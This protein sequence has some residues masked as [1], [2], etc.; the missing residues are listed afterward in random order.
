MGAPYKDGQTKYQRLAEVVVAQALAGSLQAAQLIVTRLDGQPPPAQEASDAKQ[1]LV[2][3]EA[4][5]SRGYR[6][7]QVGQGLALLTAART[8]TNGTNGTHAT[9]GT[10]GKNGAGR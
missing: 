7:E 4:L 9:N 1:A 10:S 6:V 5:L 8:S 3:V 2:V